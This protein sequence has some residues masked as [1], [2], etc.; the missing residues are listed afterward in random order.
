MANQSSIEYAAYNGTSPQVQPDGKL[1]NGKV[2][3]LQASFNLASAVQA[4][5]DVLTL[6]QIP[7]GARIKTIKMTSS[8]SLATSTVAIGIAGTVAKYRAA[9]RFTTVDVPT[10]GRSWRGRQGRGCE[11]RRRDA[12]RDG[13]TSP[14]C[15]RPERSCS[16]SNTSRPIDVARGRPALGSTSPRA[17]AVFRARGAIRQWRCN[18]NSQRSAAADRRHCPLGRYGDRRIRRDRAQRRRHQH[19][20][21]RRVLALRQLAQQ[22]QTRASRSN[23][24][25]PT[26]A[27][28]VTVANLALSKLGEDD[29]LRDPDQDSHAARSVL[30][31]WAP[32]RRAVL[33]KGNFNFSMT[34]AELAAQAPTSLG[35][36]SPY[37]FA[38]RFPVPAD[39]VRLVEILDPAEIRENTISSARRCS[40]TPPGRCSFATSPT[41]RRSAIGTICSSR[42]SRRAWPTR[43]PI[44]S[45]ATAAARRIAGTNGA[46]RSARPAGLT[47]KRIRRKRPMTARG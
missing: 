16:R 37:P 42:R 28:Y 25:G 36:Q 26:V 32:V 2:R 20:Q 19:E 23:G 11:Q 35:Y 21:A 38:N 30:A 47:P 31:V 29:Q 12:D 41:S 10:I 3:C 9:A 7:A 14:R 4:N 34:R 5:G 44:G 27:D 6:G 8:V 43:S 18:S 45:P 1:Q 17:S 33:R 22:I 24:R 40:P 15:R 39:F 46:T 13:R